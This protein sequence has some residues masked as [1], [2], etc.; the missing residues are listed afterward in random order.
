MSS[1]LKLAHSHHNEHYKQWQILVRDKDYF[2]RY[3]TENAE[4]LSLENFT[5]IN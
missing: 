4:P 2:N 1:I 3:L 5:K